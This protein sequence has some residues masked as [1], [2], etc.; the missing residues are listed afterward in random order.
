MVI[1]IDSIREFPH[2]W[3]S[4]FCNKLER[5]LRGCSRISADF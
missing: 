3:R 1:N 5:G 4:Y 2:H